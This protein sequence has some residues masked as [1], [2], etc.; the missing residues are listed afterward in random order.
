MK[1]ILKIL[2]EIIVKQ[3]TK[4]GILTGHKIRERMI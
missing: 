4:H 1:K 2:L 3:F